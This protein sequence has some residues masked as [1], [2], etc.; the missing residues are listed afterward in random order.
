MKAGSN[1]KS[2][3]S[4]Q[5]TQVRV[6]RLIMNPMSGR[7]ENGVIAAIGLDKETLANWY[8]DQ[9]ADEPY[10]EIL[11]SEDSRFPATKNWHKTFKRETP[12]EWFNPLDSLDRVNHYG[13]GLTDSWANESEYNAT[14][15]FKVE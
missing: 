1:N 7:T 2:M 4:R 11:I 5:I 13:H 14:L 3:E 9:L 6:W 12:L 8:K 15:I 10:D